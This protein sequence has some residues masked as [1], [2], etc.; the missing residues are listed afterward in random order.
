MEL[1]EATSV[2]GA[3][4]IHLSHR[5]YGVCVCVCVCGK[6]APL[7]FHTGDQTPVP[8]KAVLFLLNTTMPLSRAM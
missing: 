2:F 4:E 3:L 1:P 6:P 8:G 7:L 5:W